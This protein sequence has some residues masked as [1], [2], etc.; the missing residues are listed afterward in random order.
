ML[1]NCNCSQ[2]AV[3]EVWLPARQIL[4][5]SEKAGPRVYP[6]GDCNRVQERQPDHTHGQPARAWE[7]YDLV[8]HGSGLI[9]AVS[10]ALQL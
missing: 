10:C 4:E 1:F 2:T 5:R 7:K 3:W 8:P 6:Q 9:K